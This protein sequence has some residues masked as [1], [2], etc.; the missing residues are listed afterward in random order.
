MLR[1]LSAKKLRAF[2]EQ[3][4][5][6]ERKVLFEADNK[7]GWMHGFT[8]NYVKVRTA[9][10]PELINRIIVC[11]LDSIDESGDVN[12]TQNENVFAV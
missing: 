8:E 3:N 1:I 11:T 4:L 5:G 6:T 9:Y 12:V 7:Q 10:N 2:Y